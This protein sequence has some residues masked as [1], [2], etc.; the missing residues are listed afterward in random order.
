M[1][2]KRKSETYRNVDILQLVPPARSLNFK[3]HFDTGAIGLIHSTVLA[4]CW[5]IADFLSQLN[6]MQPR[7]QDY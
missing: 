7:P 3:K 2:T 5:E 4:I 1:I 6:P